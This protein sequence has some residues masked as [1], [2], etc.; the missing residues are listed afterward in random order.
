MECVSSGESH[1][2]SYPQR[3]RQGTVTPRRRLPMGELML[4]SKF[5]SE[6]GIPASCRERVPRSLGEPRKSTI[7]FTWLWKTTQR[8][9]VL[10]GVFSSNAG[11]GRHRRAHCNEGV[12]AAGLCG[13]FPGHIQSLRIEMWTRCVALSLVMPPA[14]IHTDHRNIIPGQ[15]KCKKACEAASC[16]RVH[17]RKTF[18]WKARRPGWFCRLFKLNST[19]SPHAAL[20]PHARRDL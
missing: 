7:H 1:K 6:R 16:P 2:E 11:G 15:R 17:M 10:A 5:L 3:Q 8:T 20:Q 4:S 19:R 12:L 18:W 9:R 13:T 14:R